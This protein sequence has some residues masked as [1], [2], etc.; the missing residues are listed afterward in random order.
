MFVFVWSWFCRYDSSLCP[1]K[2]NNHFP[3]EKRAGCFAYFI[4]DC[5]GYSVPLPLGAKSWSVI[6]VFPGHIHLIFRPIY[7]IQH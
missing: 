2:F 3:G 4:R 1:F 6:V 7:S 5:V